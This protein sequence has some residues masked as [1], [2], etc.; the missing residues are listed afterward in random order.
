[1]GENKNDRKEKSFEEKTGTFPTFRGLLRGAICNRSQAQFAS[2]AGGG[3][4]A[5]EG[6]AVQGHGHVVARVPVRYGK[7]IEVVNGFSVTAELG[8]PLLDEQDKVRSAQSG[9]RH[10]NKS[11]PG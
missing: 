11:C 2:E 3:R 10:I 4:V 1:M 7:D 9:Q 8:R 6:A 5:G